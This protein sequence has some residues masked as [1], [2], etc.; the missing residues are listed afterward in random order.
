MQEQWETEDVAGDKTRNQKTQLLFHETPRING[1][2]I[3]VRRPK[4]KLGRR[5]CTKPGRPPGVQIPESRRGIKK[6]ETSIYKNC[7]ADW[8]RKYIFPGFTII[9]ISYLYGKHGETIGKP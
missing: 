2:A 7:G 5:L 6:L 1:K 9:S 3:T 4:K 8:V